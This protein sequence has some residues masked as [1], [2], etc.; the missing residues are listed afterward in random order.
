MRNK[1]KKKTM[2]EKNEL[3]HGGGGEGGRR[4]ILK[5]KLRPSTRANPLEPNVTH[6]HCLR[7]TS[8]G[9]SRK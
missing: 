9:R 3:S 5:I 8:D 4:G 7:L 6:L 2:K 1:N